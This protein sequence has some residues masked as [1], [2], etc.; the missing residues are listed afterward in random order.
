MEHRPPRL[1]QRFT[2][3]C[4]AVGAR[5]PVVDIEAAAVDLLR[6]WGDASRGYHDLEHLEEVLDGAR[7]LAARDLPVVVLAAWFHD[8]VYDGV[9]GEDERRSAELAHAELAALDAPAAVRGRVAELV[10]VT[11]QHDPAEGDDE[12]ALLCDAD[13]AVLAADARR[14]ERYVAGVR[15]EY[16][17]LDDAVFATGRAAVLRRLLTRPAIYATA[18]GRRL[19][20]DRARQ[21][22][23]AELTR[24]EGCG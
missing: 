21:N 11:I 6:R 23:S 2:A 13:L 1:V 14:Y 19:W 3:A 17:H 8:A 16:R 20:E 18:S 5:A 9:P 22:V 10:L 12:G 4:R 24:L 7:R 15:K